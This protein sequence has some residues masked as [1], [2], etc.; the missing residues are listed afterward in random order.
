VPR[1]EF[2]GA[3]IHYDLIDRRAPWRRDTD[4]TIMFHHGLGACADV[5]HGWEPVLAAR[6]RLLRLDMRGHGRSPVPEGY[7]WSIEHLG[8]DLEAVVD[9]AGLERFHLVG[10]SIGGTVALW[11]AARHPRRV[12]TL[13]VSNGAHR[14]EQIRNLDPWQRIID[15]GGMPAWSAHLLQQ[16]F[17]PGAVAAAAWRWYETQQA[18]CDENCV[19][20]AAAALTGAD[21]TPQL[22]RLSMPALLLHPD[23]SPFIPV[24][25]MGALNE[26]LPDS[27]L[28]VVP[29]AKHGLPFSHARTCS[30][31]LAALIGG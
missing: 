28:H 31:E 7:Q 1:V 19:V 13:T 15:E 11:F 8:D 14:G 23:A 4:E 10:E 3:A 6:C 24:A 12:I 25:M 2:R 21:L 22:G 17:H 20:P 30:Q 18:T 29:H 27:R 9:H 5:W 26:A 16:R